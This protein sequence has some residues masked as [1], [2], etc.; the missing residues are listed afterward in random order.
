[1]GDKAEE[2]DFYR[3]I[4]SC[5]AKGNHIAPFL[6]SGILPVLMPLLTPRPGEGWKLPTSEDIFVLVLNKYFDE[7]SINCS[8][9]GWFYRILLIFGK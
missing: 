9:Y 6:I 2:S 1:M 5:P 3:P 8:F 7:K 4:S